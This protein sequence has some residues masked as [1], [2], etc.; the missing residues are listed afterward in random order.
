MI[1]YTIFFSLFLFAYLMTIGFCDQQMS[2]LVT[3]DSG[4]IMHYLPSLTRAIGFLSFYFIRR[5]IPSEKGR[6]VVILFVNTLLLISA[7][8]LLPGN[9]TVTAVAVFSLQFSI[10]HISGLIYYIISIIVTGSFHKGTIIG[11]ACAFS[12]LLQYMCKGIMESLPTAIAIAVLFIVI[13]YVSI[14]PLDDIILE[15]PLPYARQSEKWNKTIKKQLFLS[16][17]IGLIV[18]IFTIRTDISFVSAQQTGTINIYSYPRL[19]LIPGYLLMGFLSDVKRH[20]MFPIVMFSGLLATSTIVMMPFITVDMNILLCIYYLFVS[21]YIY[22]IA[23]SFMTLAP[24]TSRP[25]LFA[26][27]GRFFSDI[28]YLTLYLFYTFLHN[29]IGDLSPLISYGLYLAL[30]TLLYIIITF[31]EFD[32]DITYEGE[33]NEEK[34]KCTTTE[35]SAAEDDNPS[36]TDPDNIEGFL[37][38][39]PFTPRER[40][41]ARILI[42]TDMPMKAIAVTLGIS[43]RSTYRFSNS[44]YLKTEAVDRI[45]LVKKYSSYL[46]SSGKERDC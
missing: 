40:E 20:K 26:G 43:E 44:I 37:N 16:C 30:L 11:I 15:N 24:R 12:I 21:I 3:P 25:E 4:L 31:C 7:L 19:F 29:K 18:C 6:Q 9:P 10:G 17:A 2:V 5:L 39:Y 45:G 38:E 28:S 36:I 27:F 1:F 22:S 41:V 32:P 35:S 23:Y 14:R 34:E 8:L 46:I 33:T 13:S 42:Q